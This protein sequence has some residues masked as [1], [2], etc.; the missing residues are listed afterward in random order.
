MDKEP[1]GEPAAS[2][3]GESEAEVARREALKRLGVFAAYTAPTMMVLLSTK[4]A[5]AQFA[6]SGATN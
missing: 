1:Q 3:I 4:T 2:E 5:S 6:T